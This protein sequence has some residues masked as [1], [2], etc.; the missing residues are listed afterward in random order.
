VAQALDLIPAATRDY[1]ATWI[2][3]NAQLSRPFGGDPE[4]H[5]RQFLGLL[6]GDLMSGCC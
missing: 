3:A 6:W 2:I 5:D 4:A 1:I